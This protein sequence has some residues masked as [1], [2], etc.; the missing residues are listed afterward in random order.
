MSNPDLKVVL[1][2]WPGTPVDQDGLFINQEHPMV[3]SIWEVLKFMTERNPQREIKKKDTWRI[4]VLKDEV[5]LNDPADKIVW[6]G[7]ASFFIQL[8]GTRILIDPVFGKLPVGR[9]YSE[10]PV[11]PHKLLNIDYILVSHAHYDHCDKKSLILLAA[12]N[13]KAQVF[14][15]LKLNKL[16]QKWVGIPIQAA[17]WYQQYETPADIRITF[18]PSRHWASRSFFDANET[19]WGGFMIQKSGKCI[20]YSG[21]SGSGSHFNDIGVFFPGIDVA[22]IGVGAYAPAWFMS[23][24]HQDPFQAVEA[25]HATGGRIFIPFH[26]GTFDAADEPMSEPEQILNKLRAEGKINNELKI[27]RLGETFP[28]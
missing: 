19:L 12:A 16:I 15:G 6:L 20:Y 9:R 1:P 7:H 3:G 25:F 21:D 14:C 11:D 2:G 17:G 13:P 8:A 4:S 28:L 10:L 23:R 22:L 5:W 24:N 27:L 26:Y 18:L